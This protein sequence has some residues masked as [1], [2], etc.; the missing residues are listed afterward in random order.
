MVMSVGIDDGGSIRAAAETL[1]TIAKGILPAVDAVCQDGIKNACDE[2]KQIVPVRTGF[3]RSTI[4]WVKMALASYSLRAS[5][6]YAQFV[7]YG[8]SL[9]DAHPFLRPALLTYFSNMEKFLQAL[10]RLVSQSRK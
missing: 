8:T 6:L 7:E 1:E 10:A 3:L 2:A 9:A 4:H 5:A